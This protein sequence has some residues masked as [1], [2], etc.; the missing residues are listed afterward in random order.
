M[1]CCPGGKLSAVLFV[2]EKTPAP[3]VIVLHPAYEP[4]VKD[5]DEKYAAALAKDGFV[6]LAPDYLAIVDGQA[7]I[8]RRWTGD[9]AAG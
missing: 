6:A 9:W 4:G 5:S 2:P 7:V 1:A 3:G 8:S